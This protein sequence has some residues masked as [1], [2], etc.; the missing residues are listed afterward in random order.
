MECSSSAVNSTKALSTTAFV[1]LLFACL[2]NIVNT[3]ASV[4]ADSPVMN[5]P[6]AVRKGIHLGFSF[7]CA[8]YSRTEGVV[9]MSAYGGGISFFSTSI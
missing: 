4:G 9:A 7:L 2:L 1:F 3:S 5:S 6:A 8:R